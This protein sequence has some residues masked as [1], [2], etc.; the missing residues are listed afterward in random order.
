MMASTKEIRE[1]VAVLIG[2][3]IGLRVICE[4][5]VTIE[6]VMRLVRLLEK[7]LEATLRFT[8]PRMTEGADEIR[9]VVATLTGALL[10]FSVGFD[11]PVTIEQAAKL[12]ELL[13]K[14]LQSMLCFKIRTLVEEK[15]ST[16]RRR[17]PPKVRRSSKRR[18]QIKPS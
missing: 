15:N 17:T 4:G 13:E 3:I 12:L 2:A 14:Q 10:G 16:K 1:L 18:R 5:P 11:P 8:F 7:E 9:E 6:G